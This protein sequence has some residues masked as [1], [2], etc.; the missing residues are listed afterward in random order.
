MGQGYLGLLVSE[1]KGPLSSAPVSSPLPMGL[2]PWG[3][4]QTVVSKEWTIRTT[5]RE[6]LPLLRLR[7]PQIVAESSGPTKGDA[8]VLGKVMGGAETEW[9][10]C[11]H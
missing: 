11:Q 3:P 8:W 2:R 7:D 10:Q 1:P 5:S 9:G 6:G 4:N